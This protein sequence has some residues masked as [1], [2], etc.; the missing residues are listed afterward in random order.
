MSIDILLLEDSLSYILDESDS[1]ILLQSS[2]LDPNSGY[3]DQRPN[4]YF[5]YLENGDLIEQE[6][7][8]L[9]LVMVEFDNGAIED[10][11]LHAN[12]I[13]NCELGDYSR[14]ISITLGSLSCASYGQSNHT[15]G[16]LYPY[17]AFSNLPLLGFESSSAA[18]ILGSVNK[19]LSPMVGT[20]ILG[21]VNHNFGFGGQ[22]TNLNNLTSIAT[23]ILVP[24]N[25][26]YFYNY[27]Y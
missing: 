18:T 6:S 7:E 25:Y 22:G 2:T 10:N 5:L 26:G 13:V 8:E 17:P 4:T 3:L 27:I 20:M 9:A 23:G 21:D 14:S 15:F 24:P 12:L 11:R 16:Y 19:T 1:S